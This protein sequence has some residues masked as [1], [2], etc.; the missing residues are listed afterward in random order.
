V[1]PIT[2]FDLPGFCLP[3]KKE[4]QAMTRLCLW[5]TKDNEDDG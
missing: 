1:S 5:S 2:V 3:G 4:K